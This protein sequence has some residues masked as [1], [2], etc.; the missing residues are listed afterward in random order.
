MA[1]FEQWL[2]AY[3]DAYD[4]VPGHLHDACPNCGQHRL[5]L[6]F[7][8]DLQRMVGYAHFWCDHCLQGIGISRAVIPVRSVVRDILQPAEDRVPKI[9]NVHLAQ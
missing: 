2:D 3:D 5:R 9:P 8:G 4:S 6:V 1:T 7:T